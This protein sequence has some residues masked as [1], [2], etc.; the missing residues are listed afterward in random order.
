MRGSLYYAVGDDFDARQEV[1]T[2]K[3]RVAVE[4]RQL[5]FMSAIR[6]LFDI[7][8][9]GFNAEQMHGLLRRSGL[10]NIL[11]FEDAGARLAFDV[12]GNGRL[13]TPD[14]MLLGAQFCPRHG[15]FEAVSARN[16]FVASAFDRRMRGRR[17]TWP[18]VKP[19]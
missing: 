9:D 13:P 15:E 14:I 11:L 10:E 2:L 12:P 4:G 19:P 7:A 17:A 5:G 18:F 8:L 3:A 6:L 16:D 1:W